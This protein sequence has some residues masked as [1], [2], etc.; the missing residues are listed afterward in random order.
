M[1]QI[2]NSFQL[3]I[4]EALL[5]IFGYF[6][7][8]LV[9]TAID[10]FLWRKINHPIS[11]WLHLLTMVILSVLYVLVLTKNTGIQWN[12]F[13]NITIK[14]FGI[15]ISCAI[16]FYLL[17]DCFLDPILEKLLPQSEAAYQQSLATLAKTPLASLLHVCIFT[18]IVEE[19]LI[20]GYLLNGIQK[21]SGTIIALLISAV[22]F[23][24]LHFNMAQ[25][26]SA[27]LCGLILGVLYI[28]TGSLFACI[29][30]HSGYNIISYVMTI[31]PLVFK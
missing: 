3:T 16:L 28:N 18:P 8:M 6:L 26:L 27:L 17:L 9:Y 14:Q 24:L 25:T 7:V 4:G 2:S 11:A 21:T 5:G 22:I 19:V 29:I 30:A 20:R 10:L 12:V 15:A 23:A 13:S 31:L 1:K